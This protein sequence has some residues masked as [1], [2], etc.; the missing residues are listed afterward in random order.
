MW[1]DLRKSIVLPLATVFLRD[2]FVHLALGSE[3][4]VCSGL[5]RTNRLPLPAY[6]ENVLPDSIV[7]IRKCRGTD[8]GLDKILK[9]DSQSLQ[10]I[11]QRREYFQVERHSSATYPYVNPG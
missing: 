11:C 2:V 10:L 6:A 3:F 9:L 1:K 8:F 4:W 5:H 7:H